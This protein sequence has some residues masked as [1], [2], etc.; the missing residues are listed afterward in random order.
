MRPTD[1]R[2][3]ARFPPS[4]VRGL[5]GRNPG[6]ALPALCDTQGPSG[7]TMSHLLSHAREASIPQLVRAHALRL[8]H[9]RTVALR[10]CEPADPHHAA[11]RVLP[12]RAVGLSEPAHR[13]LESYLLRRVAFLLGRRP[14]PCASVLLLE[15]P[16][17]IGIGVCIAFAKAKVGQEFRLPITIKRTESPVAGPFP[18]AGGRI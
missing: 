8:S 3:E 2:R 1:P 12:W 9:C 11:S 14:P 15:R 5:A 13:E 17:M 7:F 16:R 18:V 4:L 6:V 10:Q